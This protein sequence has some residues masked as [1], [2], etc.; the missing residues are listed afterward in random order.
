LSAAPGLSVLYDPEGEGTLAGPALVVSA[1]LGRKS[2]P[3][4]QGAELGGALLL[5]GKPSR[6][7][8]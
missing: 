7:F 4:S 5:G 6:E 3:E 2:D 1:L 8:D